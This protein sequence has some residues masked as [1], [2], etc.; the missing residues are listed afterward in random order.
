MEKMKNR[1][2]ERNRAKQRKKEKKTGLLREKKTLK[3]RV[4]EIKKKSKS[5]GT[6]SEIIFYL[7]T[8]KHTHTHPHR[9]HNKF[10]RQL[11]ENLE[12]KEEKKTKQKISK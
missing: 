10:I 9:N 7:K 12:Q 3:N 4:S 5:I 8:K 6:T 2:T 11:M 1:E